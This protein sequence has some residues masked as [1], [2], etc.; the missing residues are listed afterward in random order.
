M[1][2]VK[3]LISEIRKNTTQTSSS[4]KDEVRVMRA[5]LND[6]DYK[7]D[8]YGKDGVV[9]QFCPATAARGMVASVMSSAAK[10]PMAEAEKLADGYEFK[11]ADAVAMIDVSK[12]FTNTYIQSGRKL[13]LG[14][15]EKSDV[16]LSLK[17]IE[18]GVR[19]YPK[20]VG[21]N[22]DGTGRYDRGEAFVN[23]YES[24]KVHAPCPAWVK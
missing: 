11:K 13:P 21:V 16:S 18:A 19:P 20:Q 7:V 9:G 6:R 2:K 3:E 5:M 4:M 24:V 14:G 17:Q 10:I 22:P 8:V 15:R 12:E 23:A 1:E